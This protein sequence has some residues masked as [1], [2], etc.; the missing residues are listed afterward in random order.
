MH[1]NFSEIK[2][3][4]VVRRLRV[5]SIST[6]DRVQKS[7]G[8]NANKLYSKYCS[9]FTVKKQNKNIALFGKEYVDD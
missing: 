1:V 4:R 6:M 2:G 3:F 8:E 5:R 7:F 9:C